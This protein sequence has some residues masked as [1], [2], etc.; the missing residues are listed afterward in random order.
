[1]K[2]IKTAKIIQHNLGSSVQNYD[3]RYYESGVYLVQCPKCKHNSKFSYSQRNKE[4]QE[5]SEKHCP[6]CGKKLVKEK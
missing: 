2:F 5:I 3:G 4:P 1:M 6:Y